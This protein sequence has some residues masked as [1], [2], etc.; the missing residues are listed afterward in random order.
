MSARPTNGHAKGKLTPDRQAELGEEEEDEE[1]EEYGSD[2]SA[3]APSLDSTPASSPGLYS[4]H[5]VAAE[6]KPMFAL[7][8]SSVEDSDNS[9]DVRKAAPAPQPEHKIPSFSG[10]SR[11]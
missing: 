9:V 3:A 6:S 7:G 8:A 4:K 2:S 1:E 11:K 5:T 10:S